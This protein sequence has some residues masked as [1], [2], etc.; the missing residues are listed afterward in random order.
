MIGAGPGSDQKNITGS[1]PLL[2][3]CQEWH[4][5]RVFLAS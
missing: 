3:H 2:I 5:S 1:G 4:E